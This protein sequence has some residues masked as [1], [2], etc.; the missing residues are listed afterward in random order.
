M[1]R[2]RFIDSLRINFFFTDTNFDGD[3]IDNPTISFLDLSLQSTLNWKFKQVADINLEENK[4]IL[5]DSYLSPGMNTNLT[6]FYQLAKISKSQYASNSNELL[7]FRLNQ[8]V[9]YTVFTRTRYNILG[10][11]SELGG[12]FNSFYLIG[13]GFTLLFSYNLMMSSLIRKMY[14]FRARF[15]SEIKKPKKDSQSTLEVHKER[16]A[17]FNTFNDGYTE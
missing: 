10:V 17:S 5:Q 4:A 9:S 16:R 7:E 2:N 12:I 11:L 15:P 8:N 1:D 3:S 14:I 6:S 13:F